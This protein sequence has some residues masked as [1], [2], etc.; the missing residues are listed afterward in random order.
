[1]TKETAYQVGQTV[2]LKSGGPKMTVSDVDV[3]STF[4][5]C[6]WFAGAKLNHGSFDPETLELVTEDNSKPSK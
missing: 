6:Q 4:L 3:I 1:M 2:R 5:R